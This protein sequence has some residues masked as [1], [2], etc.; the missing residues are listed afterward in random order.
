MCEWVSDDPKEFAGH[1]R[2]LLSD[3]RIGLEP[4]DKAQD[5][6]EET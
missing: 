4:V 2:S 3:P 6:I 1:V 5:W